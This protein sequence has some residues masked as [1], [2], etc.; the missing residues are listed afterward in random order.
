VA[1]PPPTFETVWS[2]KIDTPGQPRLIATGS[3][4]VLADDAGLSARSVEDGREVWR[5]ALPARLAPVVS[6]PLVVAAS[7]A[8]L[9]ALDLATGQPRWTIDLPGEPEAVAWHATR[10]V[11]VTG[12]EMRAWQADGTPAWQRDLGARAVAPTAAEADTIFAVL[13]GNRLVALDASTGAERW[14]LTLT[15]VPASILATRGRVYLVG[16][17]GVYAY[18]QQRPIE[19]DWVFPLNPSAG[20]LVADERYLYVALL[21]NTAQALDLRIGNRRWRRSLPSRPAAGPLLSGDELVVPMTSGDL[22]ALRRLD[23]ALPPQR[24]AGTAPPVPR[25]SLKSIVQS[26]D[27]SL[28]FTFVWAEDGSRTLAAF[29]R[30]ARQ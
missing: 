25:Q 12:T 14:A 28:I 27:G 11:A 4:V 20:D 26:P 18:S 29:R 1:A 24:P 15:T 22:I 5:A 10:L 21:E 3:F 16:A 6:G 17:D 19:P 13:A 30:G 8:K 9:H 7:A 2:Q 23:G